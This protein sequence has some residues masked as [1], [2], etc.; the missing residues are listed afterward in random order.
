MNYTKIENNKVYF[1][2]KEK[3]EW[4]EITEIS[5]EDILA[6]LGKIFN[7]DFG[8][9]PYND[10]EIR[11]E[12]HNIIYKNLYT[13]FNDVLQDKD[14]LLDQKMNRYKTIINKYENDI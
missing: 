6:L 1:I 14:N 13:H 7:D 5:G 3:D 12:C 8:L 11:N 10:D 2:V 9:I 4:K